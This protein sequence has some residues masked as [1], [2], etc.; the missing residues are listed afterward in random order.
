M[1]FTPLS[2][3]GRADELLVYSDNGVPP[4][5]RV[6]LTGTGTFSDTTPSTFTFVDQF[7]V[8]TN[9]VATSAPVQI[10]GI[11]SFALVT[12]IGGSYAI[13]S[14]NNCSGDV[15]GFGTRPGSVTPEPVHLRAPYDLGGSRR[16]ERHAADRWWNG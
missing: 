3:G 11:S 13:S 14:G 9:T 5:L 1:T 12:V 7:L 16:L 2:Q 6:L 15:L 4:L 10:V 8:P